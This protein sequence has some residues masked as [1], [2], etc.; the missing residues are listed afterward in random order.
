[1][2][3]RGYM[4]SEPSLRLLLLNFSSKLLREYSDGPLDVEDLHLIES[5]ISWE[6]GLICRSIER[7]GHYFDSMPTDDPD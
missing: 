6:L 4:M 3:D 7:Q 2:I 1:M 5:V